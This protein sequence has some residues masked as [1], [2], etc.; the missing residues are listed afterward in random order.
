MYTEEEQGR[1]LRGTIREI[2]AMKHATISTATYAVLYVARLNDL[3]QPTP[4][5][6]GEIAE[7]ACRVVA[8]IFAQEREDRFP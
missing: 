5:E 4:N 1:L 2:S 6:A 8:E 7:E 3:R